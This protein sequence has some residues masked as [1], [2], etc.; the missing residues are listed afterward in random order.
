MSLQSILKPNNYDLF[1][2]SITASGDIIAG[3]DIKYKTLTQVSG[4]GHTNIDAFGNFS[5]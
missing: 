4:T 1:A 2:R 3:G 5:S